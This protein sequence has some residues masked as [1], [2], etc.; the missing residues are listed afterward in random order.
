VY[1][2]VASSNVQIVQTLVVEV[3]GKGEEKAL[4]AILGVDASR[5]I[6]RPLARS[7]A[8]CAH[9]HDIRRSSLAGFSVEGFEDIT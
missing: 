1:L 7:T 4:Q 8:R 6:A 2:Q 3:T 9:G 5:H